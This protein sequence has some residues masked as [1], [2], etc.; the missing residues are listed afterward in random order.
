LKNWDYSWNGAYFVTIC[1]KNRINYFAKMINN[2]T[3]LNKLGLI[4]QKYWLEIPKH[5]SFT[6]L[7]EYTI[8]PNH[9]HAIIWIRND[10]PNMGRGL[11][12]QTP[13]PDYNET[14]FGKFFEIVNPMS[15]NSLAK[16]IR[17]YKGRCTFEINKLNPKYFQW[18]RNYYETII[19]DEDHLNRV[20]RYIQNNPAKWCRDRNN[21]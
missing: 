16:I 3:H 1:T 14:N 11:I 7:D 8:M 10:Q 12:N 9:M 5:F 20:R 4:T 17:W 15:S 6:Q 2:K 21:I 13:S 18:Q 19:R